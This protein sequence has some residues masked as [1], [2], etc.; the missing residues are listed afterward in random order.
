MATSAHPYGNPNV[1]F[2]T[3]L[4]GIGDTLADNRQRNAVSDALTGATRPDGTIDFSAA[5]TGALRA[6]DIK[7]ATA[8]RTLAGRQYDQDK[9]RDF[10]LPENDAA[11]PIS[12]R[13]APRNP[14]AANSFSER[15]MES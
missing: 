15:F 11:E 12:G 14:Q 10:A 6:G 5:M 9:A 2:F 8:L 1:D 7:A 3:A 4:S 13:A